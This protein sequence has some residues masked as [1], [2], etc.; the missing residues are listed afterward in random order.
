MI[1]GS[2]LGEVYNIKLDFPCNA[3]ILHTEIKPLMVPSGV[4]VYSHVKIKFPRLDLN[5]HIKVS[6]FELRIENQ[7]RLLPDSL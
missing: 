3:Q 2:I 4:R 6:T 1:K 7:L 5:G